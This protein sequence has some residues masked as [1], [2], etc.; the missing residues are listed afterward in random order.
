MKPAASTVI[1]VAI[2]VVSGV[3]RVDAQHL[4]E[5][6]QLHELMM[7]ATVKI[8]GPKAG[9]PG[10]FSAGTGFI[11]GKPAASGEK[12][13]YVL[14]TAAHVFNDMEGDDATLTL[15]IK[16]NIA[17]VP[18]A[19]SEAKI[20]IRAGGKNLWMTHP[21]ADVA[22][23]YLEL[24][25]RPALRILPISLLADD[26]FVTKFELHPGD[27]VF[28]MGYPYGI[29]ANDFGFPILR[30]GHIASFP[31]A[32]AKDVKA[33]LVDFAVFGGNSGGPVYVNYLGRFYGGTYHLDQ[34][35][36]GVVGLVSKQA[37]HPKT[38][39]RLGVAVV[40]P[41]Q[42][43]LETVALLPVRSDSELRD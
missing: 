2:A 5:A 21:S 7:E 40:V 6:N 4:E 31:L 12:L 13:F 18:Y 20:P 36:R 8:V 9:A 19:R 43:I 11:M 39:E 10:E 22:V 42:L 17:N 25:Q 26:A 41:S 38:Q 32:P 35:A 3:A 14:I 1:A 33:F 30:T 34:F 28:A 29:E 24:P 27:D 37:V 16:S 23:M 15:R